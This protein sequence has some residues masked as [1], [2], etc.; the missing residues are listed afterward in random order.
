VDRRLPVLPTRMARLDRPA[1]AVMPGD[2]EVS[3]NPR[4]RSAVLRVARRLSE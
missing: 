4:A 3:V 1:K 2:D